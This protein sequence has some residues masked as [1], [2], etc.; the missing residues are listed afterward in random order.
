[1]QTGMKNRSFFWK[2]RWPSTS[3]KD[4]GLQRKEYSLT[5]YQSPSH[6]SEYISSDVLWIVAV[7]GWR[8]LL[9][10][11]VTITLEEGWGFGGPIVT[12]GDR[13]FF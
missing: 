7:V 6:A 10:V 5:R 2:C 1:M 4:E 13:I 9:C 11:D 3:T 8:T 12:V